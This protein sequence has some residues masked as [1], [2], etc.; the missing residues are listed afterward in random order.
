MIKFLYLQ[1]TRIDDSTVEAEYT[2]DNTHRQKRFFIRCKCA[3]LTIKRDVAVEFLSHKVGIGLKTYCKKKDLSYELI[4]D[5]L[6]KQVRE[7]TEKKY[8]QISTPS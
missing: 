6:L 4:T 1:I 7:E 8:Q 5:D 2:F 3:L